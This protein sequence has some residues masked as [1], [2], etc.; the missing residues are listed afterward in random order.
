MPD[1]GHIWQ[2]SFLLLWGLYFEGE[3]K[4]VRMSGALCSSYCDCIDNYPKTE[5]LKTIINF[6]LYIDPTSAQHWGGTK[7]RSCSHLKADTSN[8]WNWLSTETSL[9]PLVGKIIC[10]LS[11][12]PGIPQIMGYGFSP[13]E[14]E[15]NISIWPIWT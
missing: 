15:K 7:V 3:E 12:C 5:W 1:I 14:R 9:E 2:I 11:V 13:G 8:V 6:I 10:G 4:T